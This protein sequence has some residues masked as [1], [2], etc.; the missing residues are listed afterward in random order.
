[1]VYVFAYQKSHF[2][3][4]LEGLVIGNFVIFYDHLV[5]FKSIIKIL[6]PI[7]VFLDILPVLVRFTEKNLAS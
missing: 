3:Y 6:W 1:M 7:G 5:F 2:W 4:I